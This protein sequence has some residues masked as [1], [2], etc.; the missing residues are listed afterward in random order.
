M[1]KKEMKQNYILFAHFYSILGIKFRLYQICGLG[2]IFDTDIM[3]KHIQ[4]TMNTK[5]QIIYVITYNDKKRYINT[6]IYWPIITCSTETRIIWTI[7][8]NVITTQ[9]E[10]IP[11][12]NFLHNND[13]KSD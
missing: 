5:H 7:N 8:H 10:N 13:G 4:E 12:T 11:Y 3:K 1:K 2:H 6:K 9:R